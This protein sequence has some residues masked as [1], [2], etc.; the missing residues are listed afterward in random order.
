LSGKADQDGDFALARAIE[1]AQSS[2]NRR[3]VLWNNIVSRKAIYA[4]EDYDAHYVYHPT[5]GFR[6]IGKRRLG[7]QLGHPSDPVYFGQEPFRTTP[8]PPAGKF[9]GVIGGPPCQLYGGL[10]NFAHRWNRQPEHLIPEFERCVA[11]ARPSWFFMENVQNAPVPSVGGYEVCARLMNNRHF[12][13]AQS[14][15]RR[16]SFGTPDGAALH[17][18]TAAFEAVEFREAVTSANPGQRKT[19][20]KK[21][22]GTIVHYPLDEA[23]KLQGLPPDF[24]DADS[25]F[26]ERGKRKVIAQGVPLAMGR[27]VAKAVKRAIEQPNEAAA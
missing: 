10:S 4:R 18:E 26:T 14:R 27:A 24:F 20:A 17:V 16:F 2:T 25:P 22:G 7:E 5:K 6:R 23:L 21:T 19:H 9:D 8:R 12:G 15:V 3:Y 11:E 13:E 1:E